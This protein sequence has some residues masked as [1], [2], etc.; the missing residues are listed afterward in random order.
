MSLSLNIAAPTVSV[1][2]PSVSFGG[3]IGV[4]ATAGVGIGG[5]ASV[6]VVAPSMKIGAS[7]ITGGGMLAAFKDNL[8]ATKAQMPGMTIAAPNVLIGAGIGGASLSIAAPKVTMPNLNVKIA[9]PSVS[10][11]TSAQVWLTCEAGHPIRK[12]EAGASRG[13]HSEDRFCDHCRVAFKESQKTSY[14]CDH[15]C[16]YD[17]C[18]ECFAKRSAARAET[19]GSVRCTACNLF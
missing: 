11:K 14:N 9:T 6:S 18:E 1:E 3:N 12:Y 4:N 2:A 7:K 17:C 15:A 19:S 8:E 10:V 5:S 13:R 16:D